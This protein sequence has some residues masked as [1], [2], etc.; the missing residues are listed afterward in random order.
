MDEQLKPIDPNVLYT[1]AEAAQRLRCSV[2]TILRRIKRKELVGFRNGTGRTPYV[3]KGSALLAYIDAQ[4]KRA[5][6]AP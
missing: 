1:S 5:Q 2:I 6:E 4:E 3:V